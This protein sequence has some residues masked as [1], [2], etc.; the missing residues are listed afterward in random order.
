LEIFVS[1]YDGLERR[2]K[3]RRIG[4]GRRVFSDRRVEERRF[5]VWSV[6][7]TEERRCNLDRRNAKR[8]LENRRQYP[9]RRVAHVERKILKIE[10]V[11]GTA[12][13]V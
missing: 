6:V 9:N 7:V 1:N 10:V 12:A 13:S 4:A 11:S 2:R 5:D 8:R 3:Q